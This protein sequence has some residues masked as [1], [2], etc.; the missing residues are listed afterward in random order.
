[1]SELAQISLRKLLATSGKPNI[2]G[3]KKESPLLPLPTHNSK[4][5]DC[6]YLSLSLFEGQWASPKIEI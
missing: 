4:V 2:H 6:L 3:E 1:M 5:K